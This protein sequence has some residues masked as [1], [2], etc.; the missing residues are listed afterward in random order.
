MMLRQRRS[1]RRPATPGYHFLDCAGLYQWGP[2]L[3]DDYRRQAHAAAA[4]LDLED[5]HD[6]PAATEEDTR[7]RGLLFKAGA[8][9]AMTDA[10][11]AQTG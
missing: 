4:C 11:V 10:G 2:D 6:R 8:S 5:G 9:L 1:V 7:A 3:P